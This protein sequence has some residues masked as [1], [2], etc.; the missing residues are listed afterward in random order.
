MKFSVFDFSRFFVKNQDHGE[1]LLY[2]ELLHKGL[3]CKDLLYKDRLYKDLLYKDL[4]YKDLLYKD[5]LSGI[6]IRISLCW[7]FNRLKMVSTTYR[8][9]PY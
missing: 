9:G 7:N 1:P 4:L 3:L 2:K 6:V 8:S 5:L